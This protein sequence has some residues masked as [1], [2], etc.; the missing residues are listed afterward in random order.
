[1]KFD[2]FSIFNAPCRLTLQ[3]FYWKNYKKL[4]SPVYETTTRY[5]RF[6][7]R[8]IETIGVP[9]IGILAII[10]YPNYLNFVASLLTMSGHLNMNSYPFAVPTSNI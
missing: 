6:K 5:L 7:E 4:I 3:Q 10:Y 8:F 9:C 2:F 1:M